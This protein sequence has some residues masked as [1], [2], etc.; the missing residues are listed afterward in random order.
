MASV[1]PRVHHLDL[2]R[3]GET[4]GGSRFRGRL[5][6]PLT[7]RGWEQMWAAVGP[8][9][10]GGEDVRVWDGIVTSPLARCADFARAL[11][12]RQGIP[13]RM[14]PRLAE[15]DFG[16]WEG[17]TAADLMARDAEALGRFWGDP[18]AHPPP[19]GEPLLAFQARV[20]AAWD[21]LLRQDHGDRTLVISHGGVIR[22]ILCQVR[23][24]P[25]GRLLELDVGHASL[26]GI[27]V[28]IGREGV[29]VGDASGVLARAAAC[30]NEQ[31]AEEAEVEMGDATC[32][33][34]SGEAPSEGQ[35]AED[36]KA[37][38]GDARGILA[39]GEALIGP[40]SRM[41]V[42]LIRYSA[43]S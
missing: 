33:P 35:G 30:I 25:Q 31:G 42:E 39:G 27:R 1:T 38:I 10:G 7:E 23:G 32:I 18:V 4:L 14:D 2:L 11:S 28:R 37:G 15:L 24:Y 34:A 8:G 41:R 9:D 6:D 21:E 5:D 40:S 3:H 26:T 17:Q 16:D 29:E 12:E 13:L 43:D 20:L 22:V 36:T 19:G